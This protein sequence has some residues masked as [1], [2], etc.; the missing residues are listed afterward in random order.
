MNNH[1]GAPARAAESVQRA[2]NRFGYDLALDGVVGS[3]TI[4]AI[5]DAVRQNKALAYNAFRDEWIAYLNTTGAT[6]RQGLLNRMNDN[7]PP[8]PADAADTATYADIES[9]GA[10]Y[11]A[12]RVKAIFNG[13]FRG[14]LKDLAAVLALL[15]GFGLLALSILKLTA[16]KTATIPL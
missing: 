5:N 1:M 15:L 4:A 11:Q 3:K 2:L 13:A 6:F 12:G 9:G 8:M 7:F 16:T 14:D 10:Q